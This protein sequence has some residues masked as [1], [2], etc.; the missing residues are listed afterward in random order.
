MAD[1]INLTEILR[2]RKVVRYLVNGI[3]LELTAEL[4]EEF[5]FRLENFL[6]EGL[7]LH[8]QQNNELG[9]YIVDEIQIHKDEE[10]IMTLAFIDGVLTFLMPDTVTEEQYALYGKVAVSI[11]IF[12]ERFED[13]L[14]FII[15]DL[16]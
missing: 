14:K 9:D 11:V 1:I 4:L 15:Q 12:W 7:G 2:K 6:H 5:R 13:D 3:P 8:I 10:R 16:D